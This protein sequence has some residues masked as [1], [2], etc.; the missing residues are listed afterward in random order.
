ME[1]EVK[2]PISTYDYILQNVFLDK[3]TTWWS[4]SLLLSSL[5]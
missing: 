3:K 2:T 4:H 5:P 1:T